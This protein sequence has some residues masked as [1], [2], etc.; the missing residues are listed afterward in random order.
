MGYPRYGRGVVIIVVDHASTSSWGYCSI[1]V[2][3]T[4]CKRIHI[5]KWKCCK[6]KDKKKDHSIRCRITYRLS[7]ISSPSTSTNINTMIVI[8]PILFLGATL[9][10]LVAMTCWCGSC[11]LCKRT[12]ACDL[13]QSVF[14]C[15]IQVFLLVTVVMLVLCILVIIGYFLWTWGQNSILNGGGGGI[16][17][18]IVATHNEL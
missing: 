15:C 18:P 2:S 11:L 3:T 17:P 4:Q 7:Y 9:V 6:K 13:M 14:W 10:L 5:V 12:G 16:S 8:A 1:F